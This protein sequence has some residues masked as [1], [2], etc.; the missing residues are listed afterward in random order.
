M[1]AYVV[2]R[3]V[4]AL[5]VVVGVTILVF[6]I[7][8][9]LPGG[10]ARALLGA[11]ASPQAIHQFLVENGYNRPLPVQYFKYMGNLLQ[12]NFGFSNYYNQSVRS[13]LVQDLPK[14][15]LL[16]GVSLFVALVIAIPLGIYQ[17]VR[18]NSPTDYILTGISFAGYSMPAFWL[19]I[20]LILAF[21][22]KLHIFPTEAPQGSSIGSALS[23]PRAM[24][25]PVA[26][27]A[28]VTIAQFSRFMR[29]AVIDNLLQDYVR[30]AHSKGIS[31]SRV[32]TRHIFRNSVM[33]LITLLGLNLPFLLSGAVITE[34]VYNYPGMGLLFWNAAQFHDY[35]TLL[36]FTVVIGTATVMGSLVADVLYAVVDPRV[37]YT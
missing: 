17:G 1:A 16:V 13:L 29:A 19:A 35:P 36:A 34:S 2:R 10:P 23:D 26:T 33:P 21:S 37:H 15:A 20:L 31:A 7:I 14:S 28:I 8:H 27:L 4:Q 25:L 3:I 11:R 6:I 32:R 18:R 30:T 9:L 22:I 24:V 5:V 12:G